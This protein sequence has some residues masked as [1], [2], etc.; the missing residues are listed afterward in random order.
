MVEQH[1]LYGVQTYFSVQLK[2][3]TKLNNYMVDYIIDMKGHS[4]KDELDI[5][6]ARDKTIYKLITYNIT[7]FC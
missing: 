5:W 7:I 4:N 6:G 1:G 2:V 3:Q